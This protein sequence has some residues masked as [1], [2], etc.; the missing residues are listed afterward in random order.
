MERAA[1]KVNV[2][3][4]GTDEYCEL[5]DSIRWITGHLGV[6][7]T[8]D[9]SGGERGW[10]GD[11]PFIFLATDRIRSLGWTPRLSI[12]QAVVRTV[13]YLRTHPEILEARA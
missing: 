8:L 4:L 6:T 13:D 3:N 7:P 10:I 1:D 12:E 5:N 11:N 9:Y 2:F